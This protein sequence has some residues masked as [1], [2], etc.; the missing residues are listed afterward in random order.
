MRGADAAQSDGG[1]PMDGDRGARAALLE[2]VVAEVAEHGWAAASVPAICRRAG[3]PPA[4]FHLLFDDKESCFLAA[5]H[6]FVDTLL[7]RVAK[8]LRSTHDEEAATCAGLAAVLTYLAEHPGAARAF[9]VEGLL[10]GPEALATRDLALHAFAELIDRHRLRRGDGSASGI[11]SEA[12]VGGVYGIVTTRIR[13][14][15]TESLPQLVSSLVYFM[16]A[17]VA[18]AAG[19]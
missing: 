11:V 4:T 18:G 2:A 14:G 17:P 15:E 6:D 7:G 8:A 10:A 5:A 19:P 3:H 13:R 16:L 9:F 12:G 1:H